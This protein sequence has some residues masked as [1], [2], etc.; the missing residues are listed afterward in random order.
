[1]LSQLSYAPDLARRPA[2]EG[3]YIIRPRD[4]SSVFFKPKRRIVRKTPA[5]FAR[6]GWIIYGFSV[7]RARRASTVVV[8]R[9]S[10]VSDAP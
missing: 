2:G 8:A 4:L 10:T 9:H 1:M 6:G 7:Q 3:Y 5:G